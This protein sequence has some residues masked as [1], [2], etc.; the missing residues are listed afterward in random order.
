M[1]LKRI[2]PVLAL[3]GALPLAAAADVSKEDVKKL[4]AAGISDDV[5]LT[6]IRT[7]GPLPTLSADELVD[8]KQAGVSDRVL[9]VL[10][11]S[12]APSP[13]PQ[14][15]VLDRNVYVPSTTYVVQ[16][17]SV[18]Y[19]TSYYASPWVYNSCLWP[20]YYPYPRYYS[21]Y[22]RPTYYSGHCVTP[23]VRYHSTPPRSFS[24]IRVGAR[25]G[26]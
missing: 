24:S 2:L 1:S 5:I 11:G 6:Y 23:S 20:G 10:A 17:P 26:R 16:T 13:L 4:A 22:P 25:I 14:T 15:P 8:L 19:G 21:Y 3:L 9:A 7:H 12:P 18:Y